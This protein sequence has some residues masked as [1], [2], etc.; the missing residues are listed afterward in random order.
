MTCAQLA[1]LLLEQPNAG[2]LQVVVR[3]G[4]E[5]AEVWGLRPTTR[6]RNAI[7]TCGDGRDRRGLLRSPETG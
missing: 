7:T 2:T 6:H 5:W 4:P 1:K 3:N